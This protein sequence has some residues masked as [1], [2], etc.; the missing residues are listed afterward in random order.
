MEQRGVSK[1]QVRKALRDPDVERPA[2][3]DDARL[4]EKHISRKRR[5][6]VIAS[7]DKTSFWVI[8]A[9]FQ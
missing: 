9:W 4:F 5:L 6:R 7:E 3:R 2:K 1:E 8:T